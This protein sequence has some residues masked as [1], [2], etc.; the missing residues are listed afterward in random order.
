MTTK[1]KA[2]RLAGTGGKSTS[3]TQIYFTTNPA[4]VPATKQQLAPRHQRILD[5]L[6]TEDGVLSKAGRYRPKSKYI[7]VRP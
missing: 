4:L 2:P 5:A 3:K 6:T 1:R 7:E